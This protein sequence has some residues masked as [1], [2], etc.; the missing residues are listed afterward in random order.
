MI[1]F[2]SSFE[3][4]NGK[5]FCHIKE[6]RYR[7]EVSG[8]KIT[9]CYYFCFDIKNEGAETEIDIEIWHDPDIND[10]EGFISHF[11]TTIWVS[12]QDINR[13][14][15]LEQSLCTVFK[16]HIVVH[17]NLAPESIMRIT[18]NWP[19]PY[20]DTCNFIKKLA[21]ERTNT[22]VFSLGKTVLKR[23]IVG[24]R[25]GA[26]GKP[27]IL[28]LAG[29]H[30]IEFPGIWAVRTIADFITSKI[31]YA[32]EMRKNFL[33]E[34]I[35]I[36][37]PDGNIA[38]RNCFTEEGI[39]LYQAFGENPDAE[40]PESVEGRLLWKWATDKKAA[41]WI[42]FHCYLG[43][44]TNSE[45]PYDGW[46]QVPYETFSDIREREIYCLMCDVMRLLTDAPST[47]IEPS[48]HWINSLEYQLAKRYNIPHVFY[49]INGGTAG[50]FQSGKRGLQV[51]FNTI[52]TL[53]HYIR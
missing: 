33:F 42:N 26:Q 5:N 15:P 19:S 45:Y 10:P 11:P 17:L 52:R 48:V 6:N 37:N 8:D 38:G 16:D 1:K 29:Q 44:R 31:P 53:E 13:F 22:E 47:S 21:D 28:C 27:R 4:G 39:D 50:P 18:N 41:L 7:C 40:Y 23:D 20:S 2:S 14:H 35:P 30:P 43:W 12:T 3:C 32:E 36:V 46:Y 34:I 25:T 24:I 51:F 9:Y 49:E